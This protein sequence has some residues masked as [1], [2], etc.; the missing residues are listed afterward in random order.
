MS[1]RDAISYSLTIERRTT[2]IP[3]GSLKAVLTR[4]TRYGLVLRGEVDIRR[5]HN[6]NRSPDNDVRDCYRPV[7]EQVKPI[8]NGQMDVRQAQQQRIHFGTHEIFFP[9]RR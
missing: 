2:S 4:Y 6:P 9:C 1:D 5:G 3:L 7:G 8:L